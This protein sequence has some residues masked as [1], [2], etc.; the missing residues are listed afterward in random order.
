MTRALSGLM[1]LSAL[2]LVGVADVS[3]QTGPGQTPTQTQT[4]TDSGDLSDRAVAEVVKKL[5]PNAVMTARRLNNG[6]SEYRT[7]ISRDGW[8]Y[9]IKIQVVR[10]RIWLLCH[11]GKPISK[12]PSADLM[13]RLLQVN[14]DLNGSYF[15]YEKCGNNG[16][17]LCLNRAVGR[18][19]T[20]KTFETELVLFLSGVKASHPVW[21]EIIKGD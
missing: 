5:D 7:T 17:I 1:L 18:S 4:Q 10:G 19:V 15:S 21:S 13:F 14:D 16:V 2:S 12:A 6:G 20:A 9:E 3:A 8:K 11:L